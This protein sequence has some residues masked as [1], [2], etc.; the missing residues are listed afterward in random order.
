MTTP[1]LPIASTL[2]GKTFWLSG[3]ASGIGAATAR[4]LGAAGANVL[5]AARDAEQAAL[6]ARDIEAAGGRALFHRTDVLR[7]ADIAASVDAAVRHFG[8]LDGAFNNAGWLCPPA[9]LHLQDD[10]ALQMSLDSN[11]RSVFWAMRHQI[12]ALLASGGGAI[13]NNV[14]IAGQVGFG[15]ISPYVVSKHA[16]LGLTRT[17]ALEYYGQGIRI[18]SVSPGVVA[19]RMSAQGFGDAASREAFTATTPA[20]RDGQPH[21]IAAAV[22]FLLSAAAS[23]ASGHDLVLDG[24]YTVA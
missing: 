18:N 14:S 11:V 9:P 10:H 4:A 23:F 24:G 13:V 1:T 15:G 22:L 5:L 6:V 21:E 7:E 17:A 8:R 20:G 12:A 16:L 2:A 3:A 19:S